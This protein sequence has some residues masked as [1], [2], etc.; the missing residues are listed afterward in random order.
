MGR[1]CPRKTK[2]SEETEMMVEIG[3]EGRRIGDAKGRVGQY[4]AVNHPP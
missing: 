2:K 3:G 1:S 4:F